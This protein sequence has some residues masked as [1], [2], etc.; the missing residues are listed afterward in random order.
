MTRQGSVVA[1]RPIVRVVA[2]AIILDDC[3]LVQQR[4]V[5][6]ARGGL[7]EFPGGKVEVGEEDEAALVRE[8]AE[9]LAV[10]VEVGA[11]IWRTRHAYDDLDLLLLVYRAVLR[12]REQPQPREGQRIVWQPR[13]ALAELDFCPADRELVAALVAGVVEL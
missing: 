6:G 9:E 4:P 7:W 3:V 10:R 11:L 8:C 2:A 1:G 12:H 13:R 5:G